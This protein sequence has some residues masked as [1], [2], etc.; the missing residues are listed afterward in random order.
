MDRLP[1]MHYGRSR[2]VL[3]VTVVIAGASAACVLL[4][5]QFEPGAMEVRQQLAGRIM[6]RADGFF[7]E[8]F[9][10]NGRLARRTQFQQQDNGKFI[11]DGTDTLWTDDGRKWIERHWRNGVIDGPYREWD[12]EGTL[13]VEGYC[14]VRPLR[15]SPVSRE[16]KRGHP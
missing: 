6:R 14:S 11:R 15:E 1:D 8:T 5:H 4:C 16:G 7:A 2:G 10:E 13:I 9:H 12:N 3:L